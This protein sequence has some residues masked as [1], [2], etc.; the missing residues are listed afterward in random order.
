MVD[1]NISDS[2]F[3]SGKQPKH[4]PYGGKNADTL[5]NEKAA[6]VFPPSESVNAVPKPNTDEP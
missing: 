3:R 6:A 1:V 2:G 4:G 5:S